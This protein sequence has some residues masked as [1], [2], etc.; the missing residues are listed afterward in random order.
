M[1]IDVYDAIR[2]QLYRR[3]ALISSGTRIYHLLAINS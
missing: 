2:A 3:E 1:Y